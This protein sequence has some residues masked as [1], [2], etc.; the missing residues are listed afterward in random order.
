MIVQL[1]SRHTTM[2]KYGNSGGG[3]YFWLDDDNKMT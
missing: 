2:E 1:P 3:G